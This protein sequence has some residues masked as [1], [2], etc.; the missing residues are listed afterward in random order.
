MG[1]GDHFF[2]HKF[3]ERTFEDRANSTEQLL[4][5]GRVHQTPKKSA[6]CLFLFV[7]LFLISWR[8]ITVQYCSGFCHTLT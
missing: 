6:H 2:P 7:C 3:V 1:R 4:N 5:A 8:L